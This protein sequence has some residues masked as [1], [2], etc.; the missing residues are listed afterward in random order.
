[1][2]QRPLDPAQ[3]AILSSLFHINSNVQCSPQVQRR[4]IGQRHTSCL[5]TSMQD[6]RKP[7]YTAFDTLSILYT[8]D[9]S[10]AVDISSPT[11]A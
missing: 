4:L 9:H 10:Y 5:D 2:Q 8:L 11:R 3:I 1:M 7:L 6:L